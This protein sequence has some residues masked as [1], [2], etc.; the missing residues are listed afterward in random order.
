MA[1]HNTDGAMAE[2]TVRDYLLG[3]GFKIRDR[4]WKTKQCEIDIV[5]QKAGCMYFVE[6]KYRSSDGSGGGLEYITPLKQ[7]QMAFAANYWVAQN[8]WEGEYV[9][10]GAEVSGADFSVEF[11]EEI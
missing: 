2:Q 4:N 5:A 8:K 11:I 1:Q 9:L 7:R 3:Q 10:S 6:V